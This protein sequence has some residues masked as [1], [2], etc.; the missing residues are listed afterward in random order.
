MKELISELARYMD[1]HTPMDGVH[2]MAIPELYFRRQSH[3]SGPVYSNSHPSVYI[4]VQGAKTVELAEERYHVDPG[5]YLVSPVHLP[6]IGQITKAS[7]SH[8]YLSLQLTLH[9]EILLDVSKTSSPPKKVTSE[10]GILLNPSTPELLK[11]VL[12][13]VELLETPSDIEVL[14]PLII[15]EIFYRVLQG[16]NGEL[17]RQFAIIGSYSHCISKA[18]EWINH[19]YA[20]P[21]IIEDLAKTVKMSPRTLHRHFKKVT[22]MSP[23]QYQKT[24]RL[25]TARRLLLTENLDAAN[26]GFHVGYES[27]SQFNREYARLFG[28]PPIR[29]INDLRNFS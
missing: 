26:A 15:K 27:P 9:P 24:I 10:R 7:Q 12:R 5:S 18:I 29:D 1:R 25:Q 2:S 6:V 3:Q 4:I 23:I 11:A 8:P 22:A 16:E 28:R 17:L 14:A 13:L 21:L 20:E 19:H